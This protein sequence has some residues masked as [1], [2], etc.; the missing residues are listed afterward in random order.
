MRRQTGVVAG[1]LEADSNIAVILVAKK[2][3]RRGLDAAL[4]Q[5]RTRAVPLV[6][7][8]YAAGDVT[9]SV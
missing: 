3:G 5:E 7:R 1:R 2:L 6:R 9:T 8:S 4:P